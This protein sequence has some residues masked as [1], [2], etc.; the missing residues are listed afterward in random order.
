MNDRELL[1]NYRVITPCSTVVSGFYGEE[2][3]VPETATFRTYV[4]PGASGGQIYRFWINNRRET[5]RGDTNA[6]LGD[7]PGGRWSIDEAYIADGGVARD[8]AI[9]GESIPVLFDGKPFRMVEPGESFLSDDT[10]LFLPESHELAFTWTVTRHSSEPAIPYIAESIMALYSRAGDG[11][12]QR[13][14]E[15]F[16]IDFNAPGAL[17]GLFLRKASS[18]RLMVFFGDSITQGYGTGEGREMF[19]AAQVAKGLPEGYN[20]LNLGSG[21]ARRLRVRPGRARR[22]PFRE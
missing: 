13:S 10:K 2:F 5:T 14:A 22:D 16:A 20:T 11:A 1:K 18:D 17:P 7:T 3:E 19:W 12:A 9:Y 15:G 21:W 8:G 6:R 4:R